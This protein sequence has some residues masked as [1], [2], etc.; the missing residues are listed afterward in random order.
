M[1]FNFFDWFKRLNKNKMDIE[2]IEEKQKIIKCALIIG[3]KQSSRGAYNETYEISEFDFN[4]ELAKQIENSLKISDKNIEITRIYRRTYSSLPSDVNELNP[5]FIISLH[6]NA[7][8]KIASENS[9][10]FRS[11]VLS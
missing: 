1:R 4:E 2:M 8:N 5:D 7:F 10:W 3:H 11:F 6:C 9:F